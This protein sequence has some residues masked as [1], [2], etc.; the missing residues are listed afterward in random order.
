MAVIAQGAINIDENAMLALDA[1]DKA[2]SVAND[3]QTSV[4]NRNSLLK[5]KITQMDKSPNDPSVKDDNQHQDGDLWIQTDSN[6]NSKAIAMY[7]WN[8]GGW[9]QQTWDQQSLSVK[10]LSALSAD[11]GTIN[12]GTISSVNLS[13]S[14]IM[15]TNI[16]GGSIHTPLSDDSQA[17]DNGHNHVWWSSD[18][19]NKYDVT[20]PGMHIQDGLM[21]FKGHRTG[22]DDV[23]KWDFTYIGPN[24]VKLRESN[25]GDTNSSNIIDR[26][27][28]SSTWIEVGSGYG[29]PHTNAVNSYDTGV[30]LYSNG[31][32][33]ISHELDVGWINREGENFRIAQTGWIY[34][35][36]VTVDSFVKAYALKGNGV[37]LT[38]DLSKKNVGRDF[39]SKQALSEVLGTDIYKYHYKGNNEQTNIGPV[40][41]DVNGIK[42]AHYNTSEYMVTRNDDGNSLAIHNA[43]GLLIG[44][45]HELSNQNEQLLGKITQLEA[46]LNGYNK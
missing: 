20:S 33:T 25:T 28:I 3:L 7:H 14:N 1:Q 12:S 21:R 18:G 37:I 34:G 41:D 31:N 40:I 15:G 9:V 38:S 24:E 5:G 42:D 44:S 39:D 13:S 8:G 43:V 27:D 6:D 4:N 35:K 2:N 16:D 29:T 11:L 10:N 30:G 17:G 45:V 26:T 46:K 32:A 23:G 19:Y 36:G 22:G